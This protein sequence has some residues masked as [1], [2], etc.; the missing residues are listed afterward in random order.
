MHWIIDESPFRLPIV[1]KGA[2]QMAAV[3]GANVLVRPPSCGQA[4]RSL[5]SPW[6]VAETVLSEPR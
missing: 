5:R 6:R 4:E 3:L 2:E 1:W